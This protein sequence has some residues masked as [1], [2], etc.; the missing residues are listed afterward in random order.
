MATT[1]GLGCAAFGNLYAP[2]SARTST[3]TVRTAWAL[4]IRHF[5]TAPHY[6]LGQSE[7]RLGDALQELPVDEAVISTKAGRLLEPNPDYRPGDRDPDGFVVPATLRRRWDFT[8]GGLRRSLESS[9]E[10]LGLDRVDTLYLHDPD[11]YDLELGIGSALPALVAMREEGLVARVGVGS[12][13]DSVLERCVRES[14]LDVVMC[15]GRYTLLEQPAAR[16]LLPACLERGVT[17]VAAG[18][19]NSGALATEEVPDP[20]MYNYRP[21]PPEVVARVRRLHRV[22]AHHGVTVPQA[23]V[24]FVA[25]HPAV[26]VVMVGAR[27]PEEVRQAHRGAAR[28]VPEE[29]WADLYA[30][31]LLE[32]GS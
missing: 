19:Y 12:N 14:D 8:A 23:A 11:V 22:C 28:T 31:G 2:V 10:R 30:E 1:L 9:L 25:R 29:L 15:A 3:E 7:Q 5:D 21:A 26:A 32:A 13:D 24:Q 27:S 17:V 18:V 20:V 16:G 4:G 6:G